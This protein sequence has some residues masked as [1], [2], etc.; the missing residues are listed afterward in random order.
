MKKRVDNYVMTVDPLSVSDMEKVSVLRKAVT[1]MN[2]LQ[3]AQAHLNFMY[4]RAPSKPVLWRVCLKARLGKK[5]PAAAKYKNQ[6]VKSIKL[7]D[8][9]R[10]DVYVQ[11]RW[12]YS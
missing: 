5:N 10:I 11:R 1:N 3:R 8:A 9:A 2:K 6:W 4:T 12:S 7:E